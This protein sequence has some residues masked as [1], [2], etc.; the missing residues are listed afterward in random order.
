[1]RING[2]TPSVQPSRI[3]LET[4]HTDR[5][6]VT[7]AWLPILTGGNDSS[8]PWA[9]LALLPDVLDAILAERAVEGPIASVEIAGLPR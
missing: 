8:P 3:I 2:L 7:D 5:I 9:R 6:V 4:G 1:M